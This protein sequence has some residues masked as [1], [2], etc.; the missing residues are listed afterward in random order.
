MNQDRMR[1]QWKQVKGKLKE[2]WGRLTDDDLDVIAGKRQQL[3]G[4]IQERHG[5]AKEEAQR[6]V[7]D[8]EDRNPD[9][10]LDDTPERNQA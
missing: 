4:R 9:V 6:Q 7:R 2:Q 1:G 5:I 10:R 8:F 3:L